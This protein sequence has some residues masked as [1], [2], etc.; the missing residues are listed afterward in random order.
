MTLTN[1]RTTSK[2]YTAELIPV[3]KVQYARMLLWIAALKDPAE[4]QCVR[5]YEKDGAHCAL[6]LMHKLFPK[7]RSEAEKTFDGSFFYTFGVS[8]NQFHAR[9][10]CHSVAYMNDC[11]NKTFL[12]IAEAVET[13][14]LP[15]LRITDY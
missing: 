11:Q 5:T 3:T 1:L 7:E 9:F 2:M 15:D 10:Q 14:L 6:G 8:Y 4:K 13:K 12:E